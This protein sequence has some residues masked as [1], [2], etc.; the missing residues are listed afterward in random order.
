MSDDEDLKVMLKEMQ[1]K[2]DALEL[3]KSG[4]PCPVCGEFFQSEHNMLL[5][6]ISKHVEEVQVGEPEKKK[7]SLG[8][9][10]FFPELDLFTAALILL[11]LVLFC[12]ILVGVFL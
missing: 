10:K 2:I 5:H 8:G 7:F 6:A 12:L 1:A 11:I 3:A 4:V 9:R